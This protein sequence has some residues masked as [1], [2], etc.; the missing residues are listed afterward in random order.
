MNAGGSTAVIY[1]EPGGTSY[2]YAGRHFFEAEEQWRAVGEVNPCSFLGLASALRGSYYSWDCVPGFDELRQFDAIVV[3]PKLHFRL[4]WLKEARARLPDTILIGQYEEN[5]RKHK[6]WCRSWEFQKGFYEFAQLVDQLTTFTA[7]TTGYYELF[8]R[9]PVAYLP[10][11]YPA[12]VAAHLAEPLERRQRRVLLKGGHVH[13]RIGSDGFADVVVFVDMVLR[14]PEFELQ[15]LDYP[16]TT[17]EVL[18]VFDV[19][20]LQDRRPL[21]QVLWRNRLA[22]RLPR[23]LRRVRDVLG[24]PLFRPAAAGAPEDPLLLRGLAPARVRNIPRC[25]WRQMLK[26]WGRARVAI[27]M[28]TSYTTGRNAA[29]AVAAGTPIIGCNSD[30]QVAL[31]PELVIGELEFERARTLAERLIDEPAFADHLIQEAQR[32]LRSYSFDAVH[33]RFIDLLALV[34]G[35]RGR[36]GVQGQVV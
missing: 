13:G 6:I 1:T 4:D 5:V 20:A 3:V 11:P 27:D 34:R 21:E 22:R 31:L 36:L 32:R 35:E 14:R 18:A 12:E 17:E 2:R 25:P 7:G 29:D 26:V 23:A 30:F 9:R 28:E 24:A 33:M 8:A 10:H 15:V 16:R 19:R